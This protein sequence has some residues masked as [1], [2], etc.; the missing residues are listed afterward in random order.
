MSKS[1]GNHI[2]LNT[3][4][5]DMYGKVMSIPDKAM[6]I[7]AR[8]ATEWTPEKLHSFENGL[9]TNS[10]HPRDAKMQLAFG[11]TS[12]FYGEEA[13][14][15]AQDQFVTTF[16][17][18]NIPDDI[19]EYQLGEEDN[20]IDIM[21]SEKMAG[22]R[23]QARRLIDQQGVKL[24]GETVSDAGVELKPGQVLQVGKRHFLRLR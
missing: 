23:S 14:G 2:P 11:I 12:V 17:K 24:D 20:L 8:L 9:T 4:A 19:P 5:E 16:Q 21:A 15:I 18:G 3:S 1:L 13:A 10:L 22:S 7:Y 6:P